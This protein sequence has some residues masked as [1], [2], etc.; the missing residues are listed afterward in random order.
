MK[1]IASHTDFYLHATCATWSVGNKTQQFSNFAFFSQRISLN[2]K[3]Y[4]EWVKFRMS[5]LTEMIANPE[6]CKCSVY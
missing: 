2:L 3:R 5:D 1:S 4:I 6:Q